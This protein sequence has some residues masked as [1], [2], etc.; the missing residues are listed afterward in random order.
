VTLVIQR[1]RRLLRRLKRRPSLSEAK[2]RRLEDWAR[3]RLRLGSSDRMGDVIA[4]AARLIGAGVDS[5]DAVKT[6]MRIA[7][8]VAE[9]TR[10]G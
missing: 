9:E 7:D 3:T 2:R 8:E 6:A 10:H 5:D 1:L 4:V